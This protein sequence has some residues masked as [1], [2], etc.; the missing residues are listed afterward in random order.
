MFQKKF[1][2]F[3]GAFFSKNGQNLRKFS[4]SC[5]ISNI[6]RIFKNKNFFENLTQFK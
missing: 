2:N 5:K 3:S 6:D 1:E 4:K